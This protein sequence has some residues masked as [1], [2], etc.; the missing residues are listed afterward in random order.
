[1]LVGAR[2]LHRQQHRATPF[3][4]D[5][6]TL[7]EADDR[8]DDRTPDSDRLIGGDEANRRSGKTGQKQGGYERGLAADAVAKVAEDRRTNRPCDE[9]DRIDG[10]RFQHSNQGIG[11]RKEELAENQAGYRAVKQEIV[12]FDRGAY[13]AGDQ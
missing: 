1:M 12:P 13:G 4:A 9:T 3:A 8:Q 10:E 6:N 5:A 7:D 11:L 2:P